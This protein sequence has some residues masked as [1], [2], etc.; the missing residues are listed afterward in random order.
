[1]A[2]RSCQVDERHC[3]ARRRGWSG[4]VAD[5]GAPSDSPAG[6]PTTKRRREAAAA[7]RARLG[8]SGKQAKLKP[9]RARS[10]LG[11]LPGPGAQTARY[12]CLSLSR[13]VGCLGRAAQPGRG[14]PGPTATPFGPLRLPPALPFTQ[15]TASRGL[16]T[17]RPPRPKFERRRPPRRHDGQGARAL[18]AAPADDALST[19]TA[20]YLSGK[21]RESRACTARG[22]REQPRH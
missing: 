10:P 12:T 1:M 7:A 4:N 11:C 2:Q 19:T 13:P 5:G 20:T 18:N 8:S 17:A 14:E 3:A 16:P 9:R 22:M 15:P 6:M 21:R